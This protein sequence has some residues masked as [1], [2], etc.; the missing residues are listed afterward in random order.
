MTGDEHTP[1]Y[2]MGDVHGHADLLCELLAQAGLASPQGEW[3]GGQAALWFVGDYCDN[4]PDGVEVI[5]LIMQLQQQAQAAGG[6]VGALLGNH[7][8]QLLAA[9]RLADTARRSVDRSFHQDWLDNGGEP[10]DLEKLDDGQAEWLASLPAG[11]RVGDTL[12][13][14]ADSLFYLAY[15]GSL[16]TLNQ[17]INQLL[18]VCAPGALDR[19]LIDFSQHKDFLGERGWANLQRLHKNYGGSRLVHGHT[20]INKITG[21]PPEFI[22]QAYI[23]QD[24]RCVNVDGGIYLGGPGFIFELPPLPDGEPER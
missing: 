1:V 16:A 19:L 21:E 12:L 18:R 5:A 2:I 13:L 24:G 6:Q 20:P 7:D 3:R 14:H 23:Y 22:R 4:G 8:V 15:G 11:V 17:T 9:W 10:R